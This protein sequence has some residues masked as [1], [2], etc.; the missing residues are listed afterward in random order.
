M[1]RYSTCDGIDDYGDNSDEK[2]CTRI[3]KLITYVP[4]FDFQ[5]RIIFRLMDL[6]LILKSMIFLS[7]IV[8]E[9]EYS[10]HNMRGCSRRNEIFKG[11]VHSRSQCRR[12]CDGN[13][14]CLSFEWWGD[15]NPHPRFGPN[16]CQVSSSCTYELSNKTIITHKSI[17]YIKGI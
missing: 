3:D 8:T 6:K 11:T 9:S 1:H 16:Y 10:Y 14:E 5:L 7:H 15:S 12:I 4:Y 17:L 2:D 13:L